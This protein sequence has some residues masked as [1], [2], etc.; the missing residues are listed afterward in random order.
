MFLCRCHVSP[1][2]DIFALKV[3]LY[4]LVSTKHIVVKPNDFIAEAKSL[5]LWLILLCLRLVIL[6]QDHVC[7]RF[8]EVITNHFKK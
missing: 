6:S 3:F 7:Y 4:E 1:K 8:L 2:V 5:M